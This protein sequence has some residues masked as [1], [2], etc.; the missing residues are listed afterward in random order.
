[1]QTSGSN[2]TD[3]RQKIKIIATMFLLN[4]AIIFYYAAVYFRQS[5][6]SPNVMGETM[7][8]CLSG[9]LRRSRAYRKMKFVA[10]FKRNAEFTYP[11]FTVFSSKIN[12]LLP[13]QRQKN[14]SGIKFTAFFPRRNFQTEYR[15]SLPRGKNTERLSPPSKSRIKASSTTV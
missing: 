14:L 11:P 2:G 15:F 3:I 9:L 5:F 4:A 7:P 8:F 10:V 1:M 6:S 12:Y 13:T